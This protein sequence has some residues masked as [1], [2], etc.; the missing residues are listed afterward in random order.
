MI[1]KR[2]LRSVDKSPDYAFFPGIDYA[3]N[4]ITKL[5]ESFEI[6][7]SELRSVVFNISF[8]NNKEIR[9]QILDKNLCHMLGI[10]S[11]YIKK[12]SAHKKILGFNS[13][14]FID[15]YALLESIMENLDTILE[16]DSDPKRKRFLNY[17]RLSVKNDIFMKIASIK[18]LDFGCINFNPE[19]FISETG[20]QRE[21][22]RSTKL[23]YM[24]SDEIISPYY[25]IGLIKQKQGDQTPYAVETIIAPEQ[26]TDYFNSQEVVIPTQLLIESQNEWNKKQTS[27][28]QK[29]RLLKDYKSLITEHN[30]PDGMNVYGDYLSQLMEQ[31]KRLKHT[32]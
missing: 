30:L 24:L 22:F 18:D 17:Y 5:Q 3:E 29:I 16:H 10:D 8:S 4:V 23:L 13:E 21:P 7:E 20:H 12:S 26:F 11:T 25:M 19:I 32:R 31:E 9:F 6:F 27:P 2:E 28:S 1:S 14:D 15:S